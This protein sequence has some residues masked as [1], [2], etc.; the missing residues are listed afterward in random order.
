MDQNAKQ[1]EEK[2]QNKKDEHEEKMKKMDQQ[3]ELEKMRLQAELASLNVGKQ[4]NENTNNKKNE[5]Q[6]IPNYQYPNYQYPV[7]PNM[8]YSNQYNGPHYP[9]N[10]YQ[11]NQY[12]PNQYPPNQYPP[13]QYP[14]NQYPQG[15][16]A[17]NRP[18]RQEYEK[19]GESPPPASSMNVMPP[20]NNQFM[21]CPGGTFNPNNDPNY[22]NSQMNMSYNPMGGQGG[23]YMQNPPYP[24]TMSRSG[25]F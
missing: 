3:F 19:P 5:N 18:I 6:N 1:H 20:A 24:N 8:N 11:Y 7:T 17:M 10:P 2:M 15:Q 16:Y 12:P 21:N 25:N 13:N 22:Y 9:M 23:P 4:A 14:P